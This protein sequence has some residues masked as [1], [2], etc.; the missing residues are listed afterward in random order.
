MSMP[1]PRGLGPFETKL[2]QIQATSET[3]DEEQSALLVELIRE[4]HGIKTILTWVLIVVPVVILVLG[5]VIAF[6]GEVSLRR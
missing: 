6:I 1:I 4:V 5:L 2:A 3:E